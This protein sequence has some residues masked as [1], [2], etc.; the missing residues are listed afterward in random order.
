L[1]LVEDD[2]PNL[3]DR[4]FALFETKLL[5]RA[6]MER[7][8]SIEQ[9]LDGSHINAR[10][11]EDASVR[12]SARQRLRVYQNIQANCDDAA[13]FLSAGNDA[14]ICS[15]G[16]WGYVLLSSSTFL[17]AIHIA[18]K[19]L[20]LTGP[21]IRKTFDIEDGSAIYEAED[22]LL[23]GSLLQP[24]LDFWFAFINKLSNEVSQ[25]AF[26]LKSLEL[27]YP[28]PAGCNIYEEFF[29]CPV[30]F[31]T[32]RNRMTFDAKLL[33][34]ALPRA[35]SL[36]FQ[37]CD[38]MCAAM[39][40]EMRT[41]T[42][43]ARQVRDL[44]LYTPN[45]FPTFKEIAAQLYTTPRTLRRRLAEQGTSYQQILND[46]R[47]SL[48]IKFLR[49]TSLSMEEIAERVGFS[50]SRN[51]RHAFKKWTDSTPSSHRRRH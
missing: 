23:L 4:I 44:I 1:P 18:F 39:M 32:S 12:V 19:Y 38:E 5:A 8:L 29:D 9:V 48:S 42:G 15:F 30:S 20:K 51:F 16:V 10:Q 6:A 45:Y 25:R 27:S 50:D 2:V 43:P 41:V 40:Q 37:I 34:M 46:V 26:E 7:G 49:E 35:D 3:D 36:S 33:G 11:L 22:T 31:S 14:T 17:D 47:K 28:A 21:L 24:V 13:V